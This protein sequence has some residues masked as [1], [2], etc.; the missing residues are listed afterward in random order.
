MYSVVPFDLGITAIFTHRRWWLAPWL[1]EH[2][3]STV[4]TSNL[5]Y[6]A[7][8]T[9]ADVAMIGVTAGIDLGDQLAVFV[10]VEHSVGGP[11]VD[12]FPSEA[13]PQFQGWIAM[14]VGLAYH[15]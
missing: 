13:N 5:G 10:D 11:R 8:I 15:R 7:S 3:S 4:A 12:E 6:N 14:T 9:T 2:F 1:G